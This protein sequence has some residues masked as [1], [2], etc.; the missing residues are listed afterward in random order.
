MFLPASKKLLR[1]RAPSHKRIPS[2]RSPLPNTKT[3][4]IQARVI[5][6]YYGTPW[7]GERSFYQSKVS[8]TTFLKNS[9]CSFS[10]ITSSQTRRQWQERSLTPLSSVVP[11]DMVFLSQGAK[12]RAPDKR[13]SLM[14]RRTGPVLDR[15]LWEIFYCRSTP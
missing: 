2:A 7:R 15:F 3:F 6:I 12:T 8:C 1:A 14:C 11:E 4:Q 9:F 13:M 5:Y 10:N